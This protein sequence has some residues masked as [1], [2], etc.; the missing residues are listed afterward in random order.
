PSAKPPTISAADAGCPSSQTSATRTAAPSPAALRNSQSRCG[1]SA[2]GVSAVVLMISI[3]RPIRKRSGTE[4]EL[5]L[6]VI[7][8]GA[9]GGKRAARIGGPVDHRAVIELR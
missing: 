6:Q 7:P 8:L 5:L 2:A 1:A 4:A 3:L 9:R